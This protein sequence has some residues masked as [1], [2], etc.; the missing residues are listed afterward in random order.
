MLLNNWRDGVTNEKA[1]FLGIF[2]HIKDQWTRLRGFA[3][4]ADA[5]TR[6]EESRFLGPLV[7]SLAAFPF[8]LLLLISAGYILQI[9]LTRL[10]TISAFLLAVETT[11]RTW[12]LDWRRLAAVAIIA[13]GILVG[14]IAWASIFFDPGSDSRQYHYPAI[15][16][17]CQGWNPVW[18]AHIRDAGGIFEMVQ[19]WQIHGQTLPWTDV[20][21]QGQWRL[22]AAALQFAG[23]LESANFSQTYFLILVF[24]A[25]LYLTRPLLSFPY[26]V[27]LG[28]LLMANPVVM[29]QWN[30]GYVDGLLG[31]TLTA[32]F[33]GLWSFHRTGKGRELALAVFALPMAVNIK[34]TAAVYVFIMLAL[35][36]TVLYQSRRFRLGCAILIG[37]AALIGISPY[38][39]NLFRYGNPFYPIATWPAEKPKVDVIGGNEPFYLMPLPDRAA[40]VASH[41]LADSAFWA[42]HPDRV[43]DWAKEL[44]PASWWR[45][46]WS[47]KEFTTKWADLRL[48]GFGPWFRVGMLLAI[49]LAL[50]RTRD[51]RL[52]FAAAVLMLTVL[53]NPHAWWARLIPQFPA[54][55]FFLLAG[56]LIR[57]DRKWT[58]LLVWIISAVLIFN[59]AAIAFVEIRWKLEH[60]RKTRRDMANYNRSGRKGAEAMVG[61]NPGNIFYVT[62]KYRIESRLP[63]TLVPGQNPPR[64]AFPCSQNVWSPARPEET[65]RTRAFLASHGPDSILLVSGNKEEL[66]REDLPLADCLQ[67]ADVPFN[68][69]GGG[70]VAIFDQGKALQYAEGNPAKITIKQPRFDA[71]LRAYPWMREFPIQIDGHDYSMHEQGLNIVVIREGRDEYIVFSA[72][73]AADEG[74]WWPISTSS[75]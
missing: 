55:A 68:L 58:R 8:L 73:P 36:A 43:A 20:Y 64:P 25:A 66:L 17:L 10:H 56:C 18:T 75:E 67:E 52:W 7:F 44:P 1:T 42:N 16:A 21:P 54:L 26:R 57:E 59:S 37:A 72:A 50:W 3:Q 33:L 28:L 2:S 6:E 61:N 31:L 34:F 71:I 11:R 63:V 60:S 35:Y 14:S 51:R 19:G 48:G 39:T 38:A 45:Q 29:A 46:W 13:L 62:E 9:P 24:L 32:G 74:C 30:N 5:A 15:L 47:Y 27:L 49:G 65:I 23:K 70:F 4:D 22:G 41:F 69:E 12:R 40:F 53:A